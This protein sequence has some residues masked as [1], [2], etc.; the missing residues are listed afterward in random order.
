MLIIYIIED[1]YLIYFWSFIFIQFSLN[2]LLN[3]V[4]VHCS[5]LMEFFSVCRKAAA[6]SLVLL[7]VKTINESDLMCDTS[8]F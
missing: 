4:L 5:T 3:P 7:H 6:S 8:S 1:S 2:F